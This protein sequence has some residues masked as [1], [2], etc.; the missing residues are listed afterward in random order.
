MNQ[1]EISVVME[2]YV[3]SHPF[4]DKAVAVVGAEA[5]AS[6]NASLGMVRPATNMRVSPGLRPSQIHEA[7][8]ADV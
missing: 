5:V 1:Q 8:S 7:G 3:A 4:L 2:G 6:I